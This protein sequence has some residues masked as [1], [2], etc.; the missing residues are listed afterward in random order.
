MGIRR[1]NVLRVDPEASNVYSGFSHPGLAISIIGT[2]LKDAG[3]DVALYVDSIQTAPWEELAKSD[4]VALTVNSA[5]FRESYSLADRL[6]SEA[7]CPVVFGG[8][9]V[10]F[11]PEEA[12]RHG[13]FVVRGEGEE[14]I[15]ELVRAIEAG[16]RDFSKINGLSWRDDE[17]RIL[18]N[19][20]RPLSQDIDIIPDQ[21]LI[22]GFREFNRRLS[23]RL[24][25]TGMLVSTSRGCP[26]RCTFCTIPQTSGTTMR[27]RSHD[28][29][30]A[31][32]RQQMALSGHSYIYFADD[33][34]AAHRVKVKELL[35][36][37]VD[38]KLGMR[39]SAQIRAGS[40][41][42][43]E[44][45]DLLK[46]AGCYLVFVGFE[47]INDATLVEYQKGGRQN[48]ELI[49]SSVREF[50]KRSILIHGMFVVGSDEDQPGTAVRTAR[51]AQEHRLDSL[52][53]LPIC[54]L[55]GTQLLA[56][57]ESEG[58]VFKSWDSDLGGA[59]IPYGA[60]NYVLYEPT[61]MPAIDLQEELLEAYRRFYSLP[62]LLRA[63]LKSRRYGIRPFFFRLLGRRLCRSAEPE[64]RR[65]VE[66]LREA[67][68]ASAPAQTLR[69]AS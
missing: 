59:Y 16:E 56:R 69:T 39:F 29:V 15:L 37:F 63:G 34:F 1:I 48:L 27:Y 49:E 26:Y 31:D 52:Q 5:C 21:S 33:N 54:P 58:R 53:M 9:H 24:F 25:P 14:T 45:M 66:W 8:P 23:Q 2:V 47:S 35:K 67:H 13:D 61:R 32:I 44:F 43:S 41:R 46:A 40:T 4:L 12:L 30:V 57:L 51:W 64:I 6:R 50:R 38:E 10:T 18:H 19:P 62:N 36:R 17:G 3:Y 65:H 22:V 60:G 20:D 7:D 11:L 42:D 55:P 68:P 28:A